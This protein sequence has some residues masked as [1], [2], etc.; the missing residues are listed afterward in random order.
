MLHICSLCV[1]SFRQLVERVSGIAVIRCAT[2]S[3][4][5]LLKLLWFSG[6]RHHARNS[7]TAN[8]DCTVNPLSASTASTANISISVLLHVI[9]IID[10]KRLIIYVVIQDQDRVKTESTHVQNARQERSAAPRLNNTTRTRLEF[11]V[12]FQSR[13]R[14]CYYA[15][16]TTDYAHS[17]QLWFSNFR[18]THVYYIAS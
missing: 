17:I 7:F 1:L 12:R 5:K 11:R 3:L 8:G 18:I 6:V 16:Y 4:E 15:P 10:N 2:T 13:T 9:V 14:L